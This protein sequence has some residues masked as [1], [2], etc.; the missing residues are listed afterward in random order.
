MT[1]TYN[2]AR[3]QSSSSST[4]AGGSGA[5]AFG[6]FA[7]GGRASHSRSEFNSSSS[8]ESGEASSSS[9]HWFW[10]GE[11]LEVKG[12]QIVA[13]ISAIVPDGPKV[14]D[15]ALKTATVTVPARVR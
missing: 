15:P 10:D 2:N 8:G 11:T 3:S 7:I 1:S 12:A 14:D 9:S 5:F 13:Y 6:P 4:N